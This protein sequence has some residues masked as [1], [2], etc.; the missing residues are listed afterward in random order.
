[1]HGALVLF[2]KV[3]EMWALTNDE[4]V[5]MLR[6]ILEPVLAIASDLDALYRSD[7]SVQDWLR[8]Q[9]ASLD[10]MRPIEFLLSGDAEK[11]G[12]VRQYVAYLSGR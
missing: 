6:P 12:R 7:E 9:C 5:E 4:T 8:T 10:G 3:A 2:G 11:I 1:M